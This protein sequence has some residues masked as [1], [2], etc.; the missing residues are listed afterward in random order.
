MQ[1][2]FPLST[3]TLLYIKNPSPNLLPLVRNTQVREK[4][5]DHPRHNQRHPR[6]PKTKTEKQKYRENSSKTELKQWLEQRN[7]EGKRKSVNQKSCGALSLPTS[8]KR[9]SEDNQKVRP[10]GILH[11][12]SYLSSVHL[13]RL[14]FLHLLYLLHIR[15]LL[16]I[17]DERHAASCGISDGNPDVNFIADSEWTVL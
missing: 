3:F 7:S 12:Y 15:C 11:T 8:A 13:S 5:R 1:K 10:E 6:K 4:K 2:S 17:L 16:W 9:K 14:Y